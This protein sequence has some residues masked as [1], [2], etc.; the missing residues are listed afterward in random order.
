MNELWSRRCRDL[1]PYVPGEQPKGRTFIKLNTNEN[2]YPPS[3]MVIKAIK[4]AMGESLRLYPDPECTELR[5][6]IA[7]ALDAKASR[8]SWVTAP[9][10]CSRW[11]FRRSLTRINRFGLPILLIPST[12]F[13]RI[14]TV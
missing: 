1:I 7:L 13:L 2:P 5:E 9:T 3:P 14:F 12:L 8:S 10:R 6:A 11:P 4:A